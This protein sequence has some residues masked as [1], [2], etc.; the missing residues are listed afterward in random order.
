[1]VGWLKLHR[2]LQNHWLWNEKPYS[3]GQAW[4]DLLMLAKYEAG[5]SSFRG[6]LYKLQP[7]QLVTSDQALA[8]RWGWSRKRARS[9][10]QMLGKDEMLNYRRNNRRTIV[11]I[12]NWEDYQSE[13]KDKGTT[14]GTSEGKQ[15]DTEKV[16]QKAQQ[17]PSDIKEL[18]GV[19]VQQKDTDGVQQRVHNNK[20]DKKIIEDI[21]S[22]LNFKTNKNFKPKAKKTQGYIVARIKEDY[23]LED[24]KKVIDIKTSQWKDDPKMDSFLRPE[25]LFSGKFESYLNERNIKSVNGKVKL[26]PKK[27][28]VR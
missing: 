27:E 21:V 26:P 12:C 8:N 25:T 9:F 18:N 15:K 1:M 5:K 6:T 7:G 16:Q 22:Y 4:T 11:T 10:L 20:E 28:P 23:T 3:S 2:K 13:L 19:R 17:N 24:F 14:E